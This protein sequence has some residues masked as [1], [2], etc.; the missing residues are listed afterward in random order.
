MLVFCKS[1]SQKI[2]LNDILQASV[3][4]REL[5]T[6]S[7]FKTESLKPQGLSTSLDPK[8]GSFNEARFFEEAQ[9]MLRHAFLFYC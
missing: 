8:K 1:K 5:K 9:H 6:Q 3:V 2:V 7:E 4:K